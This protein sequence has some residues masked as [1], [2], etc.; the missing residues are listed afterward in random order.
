MLL[1][2]VRPKLPKGANENGEVVLHVIIPRTGGKPAK[3]AAV[4]GDP[5]LTRSAV[6]AVRNWAFIAPTY[7]GDL[8]EVEGD[9]HIRFEATD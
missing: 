8:V 6:R 1:R 7:K 2:L 5:V 9:L 4:S 3:I